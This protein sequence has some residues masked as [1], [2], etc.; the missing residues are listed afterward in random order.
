MK[1][2]IDRGKRYGRHFSVLMIDIDKA[3]DIKIADVLQVITEDERVLALLKKAGG[4]KINAF[5]GKKDAQK[6]R[7]I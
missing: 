2:E 7:V 4:Y 3:S 5:S 6:N 1:E